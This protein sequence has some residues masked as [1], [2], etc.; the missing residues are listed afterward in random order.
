M[1]INKTILLAVLGVSVAGIASA[2][3]IFLTGSTAA[4]AAVYQTMTNPGCVFQSAPIQTLFGGSGSGD[5][6]MAFTGT[7]VGGSGSTT[8]NCTWSGSEAGIVD[9]A[10]PGGKDETFMADSYWQNASGNSDNTTGP[11]STQQHFVDVCMAD[12]SQAYS[13]AGS[14][15]PAVAN[16]QYVGVVPFRWLRNDGLWTG[17]NVTDSQIRQALSG[18]AKLA[19]FT[20]NA[21]DTNSYVYVAGRDN[22]SGTRVNAFGDTGF[23]IATSPKQ[24]EINSANGAMVSTTVHG[25]TKYA[26]DFGQSSGGTLAKTIGVQASTITVTDMVNHVSGYSAIA[27]LGISDSTTATNST[28][29]ATILSYNGIPWSISSLEEGTYTF[30]GNENVLETGNTYSGQSLNVGLVFTDLTSPTTG[31]TSQ[32]DGNILVPISAMHCT[33]QGPGADPVHN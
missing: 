9:V 19:V 16:Q 17:S 22:S 10:T 5:T 24:I 27:Y 32:A 33:R 11:A 20:G 12:N 25:S 6:Y 8:I 7:L 13:P 29:Q 1:K 3:E 26:A 21:A 18:G 4:R 23:G 14:L 2:D 31:I 15:L 28:Y 30:W